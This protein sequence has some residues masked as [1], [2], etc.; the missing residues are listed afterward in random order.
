MKLYL[1]L[2][3]FSLLSISFAF[4]EI[5]CLV[6]DVPCPAG[7]VNLFFLD[8]NWTNAMI[9]TSET[10]MYKSRVCCGDGS[11]NL[12]TV[13]TPG[14]NS[15]IVMNLSGTINAHASIHGP[16][17]Q[18]YPVPVNLSSADHNISCYFSNGAD[19]SSGFECV[20]RLSD[21]TNA[22][23]GNCTSTYPVRICCSACQ[24]PDTSRASCEHCRG[25]VYNE[26]M[27]F[28]GGDGSCCG[29]DANEFYINDP[30]T[31]QACCD[32][33]ADICY[34]DNN[35]LTQ[36]TNSIITITG[37]VTQQKFNTDGV[38]PE[39]FEPSEE[40]TVE[41][42][43][44]N[45]LVTMKRVLTDNNG[46]YSLRVPNING[47]RYLVF[48]KPGYETK[49][50]ELNLAGMDML[51]DAALLLTSDC[52]TDCSRYI[53][54]EG[55]GELRCSA[56]CD[57]VNGC[58]FPNMVSDEDSRTVKEKCDGAKPGWQVHWNY[59]L[60]GIEYKTECCKNEPKPTRAIEAK[61]SQTDKNILTYCRYNVKIERLGK[62][63]TVCIV[64]M[65]E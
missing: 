10:M 19:C 33:N 9:S 38:L 5:D 16:P 65:D 22:H 28:E 4:A 29:D 12:N 21:T 63:S 57:G 39:D 55:T 20:V 26:M 48:S 62:V 61:V 41:I 64:I 30:L 24:S 36:C 27:Y 15:T 46:D 31:C 45:N 6:S 50:Y 42:K 23:A 51:Q 25:Y 18:N 32:N 35:G 59:S 11:Y 40:A 14:W 54:K 58:V 60:E 49:T 13:L 7:Y 53:V 43:W 8:N 34:V 52:R 1:L 2:L 37:K 47:L 17:I 56:D 3:I 44:A